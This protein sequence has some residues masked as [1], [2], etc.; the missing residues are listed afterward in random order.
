MGFVEYAFE[1]ASYGIIYISGFMNI[2][3]GV[4]EI[5]RVCL[6]NLKACTVGITD[7]SDL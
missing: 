4:Q 7:G 2:D 6:R 5:L 1:M 3:T